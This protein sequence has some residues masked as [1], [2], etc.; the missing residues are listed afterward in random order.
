MRTYTKIKQTVT[1]KCEVS[2]FKVK[3]SKSK[4]Y[5]L[6]HKHSKKYIQTLTQGNAVLYVVLFEGKTYHH[7]KSEV[8]KKGRKIYS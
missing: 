6:L 8:A 4:R 2:K 3:N 5:I 7:K 1:R